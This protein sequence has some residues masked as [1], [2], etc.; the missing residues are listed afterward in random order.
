MKKII[1]FLLI[2]SG[3]YGHGSSVE[4][5]YSPSYSRYFADDVLKNPGSLPHGWF[6]W[7][8][9]VVHATV[10]DYD[11][12]GILFYK[13]GSDEWHIKVFDS[14][15]NVNLHFDGDTGKLGLGTSSP[16]D[17]IQLVKSQ[18]ATTRIEV[19]NVNTG[20]A[21][22][23]G[24]ELVSDGGSAIIKR[25]SNAYT[26][27]SSTLQ[28]DLIIHESGGG[29]VVFFMAS[30]RMRIKND[31]EIIKSHEI[32]EMDSLKVHREVSNLIDDEEIVLATGV[33]GW[34]SAVLG[35]CEEYLIFKFTAAGAVTLLT[36]CSTNTAN[37]DSDGDF[38]AYDA[39]SGI[40]I[41]N[42]MGGTK[43]VAVYVCY[44]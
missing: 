11:S 8:N 40:A 39:G 29:D 30:E 3:L 28:D 9:E 20:T 2:V 19:N 36:D 16:G 34:G 24:I 6:D 26:G 43:Q 1:L 14:D 35:D 12:S 13:D 22:D 37:T 5:P 18:S 44:Y 23:A 15:G 27:A 42:R 17:W 4:E 25:T 21:A 31:G 38:C 7:T 33:S 41:K 32:S 10:A